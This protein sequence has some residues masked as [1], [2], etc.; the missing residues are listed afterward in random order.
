MLVYIYFLLLFYMDWACFPSCIYTHG[1]RRALEL[2]GN[3]RY[4]AEH[5]WRFPT[6]HRGKHITW[7]FPH[8]CICNFWAFSRRNPNIRMA[9]GQAHAHVLS[10]V[11]FIKGFLKIFSNQKATPPPT[12]PCARLCGSQKHPHDLTHGRVASRWPL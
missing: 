7:E 12:H 4:S 2:K 5:F 11:L 10:C 9:H 6:S 3:K 8:G 1:M